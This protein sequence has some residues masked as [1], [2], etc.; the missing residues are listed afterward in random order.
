[1]GKIVAVSL[2]FDVFDEPPVEPK[3]KRLSYIF[4]FLES[5]ESRVRCTYSSKAK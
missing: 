3:V 4:E 1:M 5:I 2:N